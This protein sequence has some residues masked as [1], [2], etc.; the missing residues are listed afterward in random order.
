MPRRH[1][2]QLGICTPCITEA[3]EYAVRAPQAH[4]VE[5]VEAAARNLWF[6]CELDWNRDDD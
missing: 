2:R 1:G 4:Q 3:E 5:L 6:G